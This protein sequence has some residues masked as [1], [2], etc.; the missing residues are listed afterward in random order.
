MPASAL[1]S[2]V[3]TRLQ[4]AG[5]APQCAAESHLC[6]LSSFASQ[7]DRAK[8][9]RDRKRRSESGS[10]CENAYVANIEKRLVCARSRYLGAPYSKNESEPVAQSAAL[11]RHR[12]CRLEL[13][14]GSSG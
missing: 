1:T 6:V 11:F 7:I 2:E 9:I 12:P 3:T 10:L 5:A 14:A 8:L 4:K 13:R